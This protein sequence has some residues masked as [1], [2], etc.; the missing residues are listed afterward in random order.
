MTGT[1]S[2]YPENVVVPG[3]FNSHTH[4]RD[5]TLA[6]DG[7]AESR[8]PLF[9]KAYEEVIAMGNT[10]PPITSVAIAR[11]KAAQWRAL[12]PHGHRL[13]IHVAGLLAEGTLP[14]EVLAGYDC[15]P[16]DEAWIAMKIFLRAA[17]NANGADVGDVHAIVPVLNA[18]T[19][20]PFHHKQR[21]MAL[22][23]HAERKFTPDG[24]RI[25]LFDRERYAMEQDIDYLLREV[26]GA[27]IIIC[28][29]SDRQ[30]LNMIR[31]FR[32]QG[33]QVFAE[34]APHYALYCHD[35]L[36]EGLDGGTMFNAH[37]FCLPVFKTAEDRDAILKAMVSGESWIF[38]GSDDACHIDDPTRPSGV[39]INR[40]GYVVGGQTQVPVAVVSYVIEQFAEA[41]A[42]DY[43][44]GFLS[45]N[46]RDAIGLPRSTR[47]QAFRR[48]DWT[49]P[50][51]LQ[52]QFPDG[53]TIS[54]QVA[55][56]G[57]TCKY[58]CATT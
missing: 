14:A 53:R 57:Q 13:G 7:R 17:S 27:C 37:R 15:P 23:V 49:V 43:L 24:R 9:A 35:D 4:P 21:P 42:L 16:G 44:A 46:G 25:A 6:G 12:V 54:F 8:I 48:Q 22:M 30:T 36:F 20:G 10:S 55:M 28:H 2:V 39:K 38:F 41:G 47:M 58:L 18:M 32:R 29:V 31:D 50:K 51:T 19:Y 45:D 1:E 5:T 3:I 11:S 33:Y 56:G 26:P 52:H 40:Q 34:I